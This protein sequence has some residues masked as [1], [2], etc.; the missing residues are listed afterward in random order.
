MKTVFAL[1]TMAAAAIASQSTTEFNVTS[2]GQ[3]KLKTAAFPEMG[4]FENSDDF[5]IIST[6]TGS[7]IGAGHVYIIPDIADYIIDDNVSDIEPV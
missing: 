4:K 1:A 5:L 2:M 3:F 6:F 7:P